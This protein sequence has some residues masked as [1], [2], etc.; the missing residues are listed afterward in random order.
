MVQLVETTDL[1][2]LF[3]Q[4]KIKNLTGQ[5]I[6]LFRKQRGWTQ[7]RLATSLQSFGVPITRSIIANIETQRCAVTDCQ[8]AR[9]AS[10]LRVP[11]LLFFYDEPMLVDIQN[12]FNRIPEPVEPW[13]F[14]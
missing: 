11:L 6:R 2:N 10:T 4:K 1:N 8:L 9:I 7:D 13:K 14:D 12:D 3:M 5:K